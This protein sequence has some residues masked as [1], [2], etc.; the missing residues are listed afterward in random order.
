MQM[1]N[2]VIAP[3]IQEI[4]NLKLPQPTVLQLDNGIPVY[5]TNMGTQD[6]VKLEV[7]FY[8]GRPFEDKQ[9]VSRAT[10]G[11][12]KEGTRNYKA[13]QIAELTDFYGGTLSVP[14]SL[15]TSNILLF[16]LKKHFDKLLPVVG[17]MLSEPIFPEHELQL[18]KKRNQQ[19]LQ[20]DLTRNDVVAYRK[21]TEF[22]FGKDKPYGYNSEPEMYNNI[23][24]ED[25]KMHFYKNFASGNCKIFLSGKI[26][27]EIIDMVNE[28]LGQKIRKGA[29]QKPQIKTHFERA[30]QIK[31]QPP[32]PFQTAIR[33]G[34][35]MVNK[36]HPDFKGLYVLNTILGG[37]FGSRLMANIREDKGYTYNIYSTVDSMFY[38]GCFYVGTEVGNEFANATIE[39]IY[40]EFNILKNDLVNEDELSMVRNYL[41]GNL[42]TS[43]DGPF[44]VSEIIKAH[45]MENIALTEFEALVQ[46]I[47]TISPDNIRELAR[48]YLN[49]NQM[50]EVVVGP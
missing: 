7:I 18:F 20:V 6:I 17:D 50:W 1:P 33:I 27:Q 39:E 3:E 2:R 9:L 5:V 34:S 48:K 4:K 13:S 42:L 26:D 41:L 29:V 14:V 49:K 31:I 37:Y 19:R 36:H 38:D 25:L 44:N 24:A 40:K 23:G 11:M 46:T 30:T 45:S 28:I 16:S 15:D 10:A 32:A 43:L 8:A 21:V 22:I 12:L 35:R 47:K